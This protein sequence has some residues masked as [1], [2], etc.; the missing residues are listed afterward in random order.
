MKAKS[1]SFTSQ[2]DHSKIVDRYG[3]MVFNT[4]YQLVVFCALATA[5]PELR[6]RIFLL[7]GS[8]MFSKLSMLINGE[9]RG[10]SGREVELLV[11]PASEEIIGEVPLAS[12]QDIDDALQGA[13][14]ASSDWK[15]TPA[16]ARSDILRAAAATLRR[17]VSEIA[18]CMTTEQ[19]KPLIESRT[20]IMHA[21]DIID[22]YAE[23]GKRAYGRVVPARRS[24]VRQIVVREPVGPVAAFTPWNFPAVTPARKIAGALAAG[25]TCIIKP[26]EETPGSAIYI[27]KALQDAG[28]PNGVLNMVFGD[29]SKV[30]SQL[31]ESPIIRKVSFTGS[32]PVGKHLAGLAAKHVKV[33]T[34]ELGGHAPVM[35]FGDVDPIA[36]AE[37]IARGR[38]RNAGQICISPSRFYVHESVYKEFIAHY[39]KLTSKLKVA[40]GSTADC[41]IGPLANKR[42]MEAMIRLIEDAQS[43]GGK[44]LTGGSRVGEKG[45]FFDPA[46]VIDISDDSALMS[47]EIF[48]PITPIVP[49]RTVDEVI[50]RANSL[51]YGLAAYAY[52]SSVE[53]SMRLANEIE[54]GMLGINHPFI[55]PPEIPF[56]GLK[57]SGYGSEGGTEGLAAYTVTR[58]VSESS[59]IY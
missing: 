29:P 3:R 2:K 46:V 32:I 26:S 15:E 24:G 30:S 4:T 14:E 34:M 44:V 52:T 12:S 54:A 16:M 53:I 19:G 31:I 23:E 25:C 22:W 49:F 5:Y 40:P 21:A 41:E 33:C 35:V 48:G 1:G 9:W 59:T 18:E 50:A 36:A 6:R 17:D 38:Y 55:F 57:E 20:E 11:D 58:F 47:D 28:L 7:R 45:Y 13:K 42:R 43:R 56:G 8:Q 39:V 27:A 51:P 10:T 37:S